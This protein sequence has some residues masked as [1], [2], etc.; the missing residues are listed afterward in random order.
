[1]EDK[2]HLSNTSGRRRKENI[3]ILSLP[4]RKAER[5]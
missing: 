2:V 5:K 3:S 1:M 4:L